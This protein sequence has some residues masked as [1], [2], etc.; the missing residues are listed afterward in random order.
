MKESFYSR[1]QSGYDYIADEANCNV[2]LVRINEIDSFF[3][4]LRHIN[5]KLNFALKKIF[6]LISV[7]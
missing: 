3:A 1:E 7:S 6:D 2:C 5:K 4:S